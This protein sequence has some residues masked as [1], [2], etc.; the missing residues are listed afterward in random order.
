MTI[1]NMYANSSIFSFITVYLSFNVYLFTYKLV[2]T[3]FNVSCGLFSMPPVFCT[4]PL[5]YLTA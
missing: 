3:N 1:K 2:A 5:V 4:A